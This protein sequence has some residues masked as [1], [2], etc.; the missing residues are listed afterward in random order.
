MGGAGL[1]PVRRVA[2]ALALTAGLCAAAAE[3]AGADEI[4]AL[5]SFFQT[6]E[7]ATLAP[8]PLAAALTAP[9]VMAPQGARA[10]AAPRAE[11]LLEDP[12]AG[13]APT[14]LSEAARRSLS[15]GATLAALGAGPE[16]PLAGREAAAPAPRVDAGARLRRLLRGGAVETVPRPEPMMLE[17]IF[18]GAEGP[19]AEALSRRD[20][21]I[22]AGLML[23][24]ARGAA[25]D[26]A[27]GAQPEVEEPLPPPGGYAVDSEALDRRMMLIGLA[28]A[29]GAAVAGAVIFSFAP[30]GG[31]TLRRR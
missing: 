16:D 6:G 10:P 1:S 30:T 5:D 3:R 27:L 29:A 4:G 8:A 17:R 12:G 14:I 23:A 13:G 7:T 11:L 25:L 22:R 26:P 15:G 21:P 31:T 19:L 28:L 2:T 24:S 20:D 9:P 18:A